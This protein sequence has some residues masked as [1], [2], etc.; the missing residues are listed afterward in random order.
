MKNGLLLFA[1]LVLLT[2]CKKYHDG[3][4]HFN[5]FKHLEGQWKLKLYEVDG[6][7]ST[8]LTQGATTIPDYQEEFARFPMLHTGKRREIKLEN[9]YRDYEVTMGNKKRSII[10]V[11]NSNN[12]NFDPSGCLLYNSQKCQRDVF[13]P[14]NDSYFNWKID[15][16][17]KNELVLVSLSYNYKLILVK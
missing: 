4:Y 5:A 14:T 13:N 1:C 9:H 7:D 2:T 12:S 8:M 16:L 11:T 15:K 10:S 3:G 6:I 17:T